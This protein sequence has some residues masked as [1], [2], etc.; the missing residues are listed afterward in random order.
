MAINQLSIFLENKPG[1]LV[2]VTDAL[3]RAG[4]DIR[5]MSL[6]DTQ[7]FGILRLIVGDAEGAKRILSD[8]GC[9]VSITQV[10]G[11]AVADTPGALT[12]VTSLLCEHGINIEYMYAFLTSRGSTAYVVLRV[13]D[14]DAAAKLLSENGIELIDESDIKTL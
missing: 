8:I 9:V 2:L 5:A 1:T 13:N 11:V 6:A 14:N 3:G 10:I 4:I 12:A 7:D